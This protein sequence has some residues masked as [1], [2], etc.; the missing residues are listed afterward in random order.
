MKQSTF[1]YNKV[2]IVKA[3][4]YTLSRNERSY[5]VTRTTKSRVLTNQHGRRQE[6]LQRGWAGASHDKFQN[7]QGSPPLCCIVNVH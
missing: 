7:F 1:F 5:I 2:L 4:I 3:S 6:F